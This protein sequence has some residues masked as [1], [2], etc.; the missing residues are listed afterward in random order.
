MNTG[1]RAVQEHYDR[2]ALLYRA[3]WGEHI[4]HGYWG[5]VGERRSDEPPWLAQLRLIEKL[6]DFSG[7]PPRSVVLDVGCGTG[8]ASFWLAEQHA[9]EVLGINIS[10][11]QLKIARE[12]LRLK[13]LDDK[14]RF[15]RMDAS[16]LRL[17]ASRFDAL[18]AVESVEHLADKAGF[19]SQAA[20]LLRPGG[21]LAIASW[22]SGPGADTPKGRKLLEKIRTA[23]LCSSLP[24]REDTLRWI[25]E[26]GFA[27][28]ES[29]DISREVAPT[30]GYC[31]DII[32]RPGVWTLSRVMG[33]AVA[34]FVDAFELMVEAYSSR[35]LAYGL[36][37]ARKEGSA[38]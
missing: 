25:T 22:L 29:R 23:M 4:H 33:D 36:F 2:L 30:W 20:R 5:Y 15:A 10:P 1:T 13:N 35:A 9:C 37:A 27:R 24:T 34:R 18:W 11:V 6:V 12:H 16:R 26:A 14:V 28:A 19:L 17:P 32:E 7:L 31:L 21:T 8:G 38:P 3:L